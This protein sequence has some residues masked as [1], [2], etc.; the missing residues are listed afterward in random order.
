[1]IIMTWCCSIVSDDRLR[2]LCAIVVQSAVLLSD[3]DDIMISRMYRDAG[4]VVLHENVWLLPLWPLK[5]LLLDERALRRP[6]S[7]HPVAR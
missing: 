5:I 7:V 3:S 1:M 6:A 2:V 4:E